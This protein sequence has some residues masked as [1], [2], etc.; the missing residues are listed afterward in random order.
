MQLS[1]N[2]AFSPGLCFEVGLDCDSCVRDSALETAKACPGLRGKAIGQLF[3]L[4][5]PNSA[6][7]PMHQRFTEEYAN[8]PGELSLRLVPRKPIE[9]V[10]PS[11]SAA[12][13]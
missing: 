5:Y 3:V 2:V 12:V 10:A 9:R 4:L 1:S 6:C 8:A 13:A 11:V 7:A